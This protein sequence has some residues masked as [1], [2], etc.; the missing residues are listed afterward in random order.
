MDNGFIYGALGRK[1]RLPNVKSD[2]KGIQG[3]EVRSGLTS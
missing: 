3:H 1:R 2:N